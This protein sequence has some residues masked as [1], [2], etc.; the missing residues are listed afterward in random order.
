MAALEAELE[1]ELRL[2]KM[3]ALE[4]ELWVFKEHSLM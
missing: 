2:K 1:A 3:V 4:V